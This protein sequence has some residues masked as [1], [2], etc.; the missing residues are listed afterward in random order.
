MSYHQ[1]Q[2]DYRRVED[3]MMISF[4][5]FGCLTKNYLVLEAQILP[6]DLTTNLIWPIYL[7]Q[8]ADFKERGISA[9]VLCFYLGAGTSLLFVKNLQVPEKCKFGQATNMS[10]LKDESSS[11]TLTC[12]R[13]NIPPGKSYTPLTLM[14]W[15]LKLLHMDNCDFQRNTS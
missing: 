7:N 10:T 9:A 2:I 5:Y 12:S 3:T 1:R 4:P 8:L 13:Q 15:H 14:L 11:N 6:A